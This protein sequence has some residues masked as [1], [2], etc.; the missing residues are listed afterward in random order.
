MPA[1]TRPGQMKSR[2]RFDKRGTATN[3]GYGNIISEFAEQFT[4]S[5]E[6][7]PLKGGETVMAARLEGKQPALI[8]VRR[9]SLTLTIN[10]NWRCAEIVDG[11]S[12]PPTLGP[13]FN[14]RGDPQD[15]EQDKRFLTMVC[16][17]GGADG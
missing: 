6:I 4:R 5:A 2:V 11:T 14:I 9:D 8:I 13:W 12:S 16:D 10:T 1:A 7:K 15:M 3:D 17:S